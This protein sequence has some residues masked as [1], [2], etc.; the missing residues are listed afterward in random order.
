M[1]TS[2]TWS[3]AR[4]ERSILAIIFVRS[5]DFC[6]LC[7]HLCCLLDNTELRD[8]FSS[9]SD[10]SN[11]YVITFVSSRDVS[12]IRDQSSLSAAMILATIYVI[13]FVSSR[14]ISRLR[15]HLC[16]FSHVISAN[17]VIII[18]SSRDMSKVGGD[19]CQLT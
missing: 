15:H 14:D 6:N 18:D 9:S 2:L 1:Q 5:R 13:I 19:L 10:T 12:I 16:Q 3:S 11:N 4:L 8:F 17:S 7:H